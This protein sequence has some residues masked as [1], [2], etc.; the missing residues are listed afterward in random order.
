MKRICNSIRPALMAIVIG[1]AASL[2]QGATIP[3]TGW[4]VHNQS[5][6]ASVVTDAGT[7]SPT[8]TPADQALTVLGTFP[9]V[10]LANDGDFI[11]ASTT[12]MMSNR[13]GNTGVNA[14]NTQLRF[15]IYKGPDGPVTLQDIPNVGVFVTYANN[16]A[17]Q[18]PNRRLRELTGTT[19]INP[20]SGTAD[21]SGSAGPD[22]DND[23]IQ[24]ANPGP[25][26]FEMV[27]TRNAGKLDITA[28]I[29]G[30]DPVTTRQAIWNYTATGYDPVNIG[31]VFNRVG[32][33]F[34]NNTDAP[35][36]TLANVTITTIPEPASLLLAAGLTFG[37]LF[38]RKRRAPERADCV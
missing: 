9:N 19:N 30:T 27:M 5:T 24:G 7:N 8:F 21:I 25:V 29:S 38:T 34:G 28:Q 32:F 26:Y 12:L 18:D 37:S 6:P 2:A 17:A 16:V 31:T 20:F 35:S 3:V 1:S 10:E 11:K 4:A 22:T 14:L 15:G 13:F 36:A 33:F 23:S